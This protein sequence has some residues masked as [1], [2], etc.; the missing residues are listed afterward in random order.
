MFIQM[1]KFMFY[2][3]V[4]L[5]LCGVLYIIGTAC[6]LGGANLLISGYFN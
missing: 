2:L 5:L 6:V 4:L 3:G 1:A